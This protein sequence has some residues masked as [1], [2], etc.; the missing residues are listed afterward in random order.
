[1]VTFVVDLFDRSTNGV[2]TGVCTNINSSSV[3]PRSLQCNHI[4]QCFF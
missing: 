2:T 3:E 4:C 1:M